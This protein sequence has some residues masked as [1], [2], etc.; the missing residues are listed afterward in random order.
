MA[1]YGCV[2]VGDHS[3]ESDLPSASEAPGRPLVLI[4]AHGLVNW[5]TNRI[6]F[7]YLGYARLC[8]D[9]DSQSMLIDFSDGVSWVKRKHFT[10]T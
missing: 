10:L 2:V 5:T 8:I 1:K 3:Y 7:V 4:L 9:Y 6:D